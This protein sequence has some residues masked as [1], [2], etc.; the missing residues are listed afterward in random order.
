MTRLAIRSRGRGGA[1]LIVA[2]WVLLILSLLVGSFAY[3]MHIESH[4]TSYFRKRMKAQYLARAGVEWAKLLI[5]KSYNVNADEESEGADEQ[6]LVSAVNLSRGVGAAK[7]VIALGEGEVTVDVLPEQGR[8][9]INMLEDEDWEELLDSTNV[10]EERWDELIDTFHD[11]VDENDEHLLNG[12][13]SD[14]SFYEERGY[15]VKNA[16]LDTIDELLLIK[17]FDYAVVY[18]GPG[19][20]EDDPPLRGIGRSLTTWGDGKVN[21]N[22][23]NRDVLMTLPG[24][25]DEQTVDGL[26]EQRAGEDGIPGTRDDGFTSVEEVLGI[27]GIVDPAALQR[28]ITVTERQYVRVVSIGEVQGVRSGVW[29]VLLG[30]EELVVPLY[31]REEAME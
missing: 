13:E 10:P 23:A 9:N 15:E 1:A 22:T 19:E 7:R 3:D 24:L 5:A 21:V 30:T 18:G 25:E 14:D 28:R 2:L 11:W 8:Y 26:L 17:G 27:A 29:A 31:W 20:T 16:P 4:V 6:L 12:A